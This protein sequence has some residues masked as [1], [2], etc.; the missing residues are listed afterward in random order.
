MFGLGVRCR[1]ARRFQ[2]FGAVVCALAAG[3][4]CDQASA[5]NAKRSETI[6]ERVLNTRDFWQIPVTYYTS[7]KGKAAP[8]VVLLPGKNGNR[9]DWNRGFAQKL[10]KEGYAVVAVD[11]RKFGQARGPGA[12]NAGKGPGPIDFRNMILFDMPAVKKFIYEEH[13]KENLNMRKMAII[14]PDVSAPVAINFSGNDWLK[15]PWPDANDFAFRTPRGQDVRALVLLSPQGNLPGVTTTGNA[16]RALREPV[17][18]I[19]FLTCYGN[20]DKLDKGAAEKMHQKLIAPSKNE[21]RMYLR[22]YTTQLRGTDL[23]GRKNLDIEIHILGF[24]KKHLMSLPDPWRNR[25]S[26]LDDP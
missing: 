10:R 1:G 4:V 2:W 7:T 21:D 9:R 5:Q 13:Q 17:R 26:R 24:L 6:E 19:A 22:D 25:K 18:G 8:V 11:L 15:R 14:A 3:T 16:L 23:I 20:R 12:T